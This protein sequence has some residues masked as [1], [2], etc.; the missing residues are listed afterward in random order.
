[1]AQRVQKVAGS[2]PIV[3][4]VVSPFDPC[5]SGDCLTPLSQ[6]YVALDK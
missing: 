5:C 6:S 2:N 1:M 3:R 4:R